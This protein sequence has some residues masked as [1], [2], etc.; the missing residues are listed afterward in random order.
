MAP[1]VTHPGVTR[2]FVDVDGR[3]VHYARAGAGPVVA[4]AHA[5]PQSH[6]ALLPLMR[7]LTA[8][9]TVFAFDTPGYGASAPLP[10]QPDGIG[11][12]GDALAA[13]LRALGLGPVPVY[14]THTGVGIALEAANRHPDIVSRA[15]L[16]GFAV[17]TPQEREDLLR[18]HLPPLRPLWD[19]SH[20]TA[21]CSR[22]RDQSVFFPWF[23]RGDSARRTGDPAPV[24]AQH[25]AT[26]DLLHAGPH[27]AVAYA[28]SIVHD[29]AALLVAPDRI[30]V[31][32]RSDDILAGHLDRLPPGVPRTEALARESWADTIAGLLDG[33]PAAT[34]PNNAP[35]PAAPAEPR[36]RRYAQGLH[37]RVTGNAGRP[38]LVLHD[39]PGSS[40]TALPLA[41][42]LAR[43]RSVILPD[44]PGWGLSPPAPGQ[45]DPEQVA[46]MV[47]AAVATLGLDELD[48]VGLG[49]GGL[50]APRVARLL[51]AR[52]VAAL[53]MPDAPD[54]ALADAYPL[55]VTPRWDGAHLLSAWFRQRDALLFRP[56]FDRRAAAASYPARPCGRPASAAGSRDGD[57]GGGGS[58]PDPRAADGAG[59]GHPLPGRNGRQAHRLA[60]TVTAGTPCV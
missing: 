54:P 25:R 3:L 13:T 29:P 28:A 23:R 60:R 43:G 59:G 41:R 52:N 33:V 19:G 26:L 40:L 49:I 37:L 30:R 34:L 55:D 51:G 27:V 53:D 14:G 1:D 35:V 46:G 32:C 24:A 20:M 12:F 42:R 18:D 6:R 44:L 11:A 48:V 45:D 50:L 31:T 4:M 17:F 47:A 36:R 22:V 16:D 10:G 2:H 39:L 8:R 58:R 9:F 38:L 5:S 15:V 56:W 21:L 57:A 7:R